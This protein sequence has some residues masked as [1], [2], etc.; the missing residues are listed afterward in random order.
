MLTQAV[1]VENEKR[2]NDAGPFCGDSALYDWYEYNGRHCFG[3]MN[4]IPTIRVPLYIEV[5][6]EQIERH[7]SIDKDE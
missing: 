5:E 1:K 3:I 6:I 2:H 4:Q 7:R